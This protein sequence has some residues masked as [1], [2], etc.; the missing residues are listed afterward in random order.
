MLPGM[1][2][3][4]VELTPTGVALAGVKGA[5]LREQVATARALDL[6]GADLDRLDSAARS[7]FETAGV[8]RRRSP[9]RV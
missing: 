9:G 1:A 4:L 8:P 7:A 6:L 5:T 2:S 3:I